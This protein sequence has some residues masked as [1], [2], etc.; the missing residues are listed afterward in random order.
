MQSDSPVIWSI[1]DGKIG[2]RVQCE[3]VAQ[4]L[5][6]TLITKT[7]SPGVPWSWFAPAGPVPFKD[8]PHRAGSLLAPPFPDILIASGR[9]AIPYARAVKKENGPKTYVVLLKDPRIQAG[10][11]DLIWAPSHDH[12]SGQNVVSTLTSPHGLSLQ[13]VEPSRKI[14]PAIF[15]LPRPR[16]GIVLGGVGA[17]TRYDANAARDLAAKIIVAMKSFESF[18]L[19]PSRR[20]P[21][22]FLDL[23][24][25]Q[26]AGVKGYVWDGN[27]DNPYLD[28]LT[29][30]DALLVAGDSHNMVSEVTATSLPVYI[31][32][33]KGLARK[34]DW[35]LT[36]LEE[37][38]RV[39]KLEGPVE[40]FKVTPIDATQ[41]IVDAI[42]NGQKLKAR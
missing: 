41:T 15:D 29:S 30:S 34:F 40:L 14:S 6:G 28:I 1:T 37:L 25:S 8:A 24:I 19:T 21:P 42:C 9:R 27:G 2:D 35:F 36:Q 32:R 26:L 18:I 22:A 10:F 38:G 23:L 16:L 3:G 31:W 5:G 33:P 7:V 17:G 13:L 4:A 39:R 20:T 11:A 12:R